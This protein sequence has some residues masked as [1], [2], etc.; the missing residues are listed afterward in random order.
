MTVDTNTK[1]T[2]GSDSTGGGIGYLCFNCYE[3]KHGEKKR[4]C[5]KIPSECVKC[6]KPIEIPTNTKAIHNMCRKETTRF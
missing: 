3:K 1:T 6:K 2:N 4:P 5:E